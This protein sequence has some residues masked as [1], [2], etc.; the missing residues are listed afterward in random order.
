MG[1]WDTGLFS[2]DTTSDVRDT[3]I[4]FLKQQLSNED[5]YQKTYEEYKDLI[6]T[7]DE[8][9]F[10]YALADTQWNVGRLLPKVRD[11]ALEFI[12]KKGGDSLWGQNLIGV[13][14]WEST[15][16]KLEEKIKKPIPA[17]KNFVNSIGFEQNPWNIGDIYAYQFHTKKSIEHGL[18]G[19]YILL[20]KIGN[21]E[22]YKDTIFSVIQVFN[23][24]FDFVPSLDVLESIR[25]LPLVDSPAIN[26]SPKDI[27]S[28]LPTFEWYMKATML[29]EKKND[30]PK[31]YLTFV[32]NIKVPEMHCAGND[33]TDFFWDKNA[34]EDWLI[35]YYLSWQNIE[36]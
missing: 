33:F 36:Y 7:E 9:L 14:K 25:V 17:E 16:L 15:L 23:C 4:K 6:G 3:Y 11:T 2:N 31:R 20:Q 10:W 34:M 32:G 27:A 8:P 26:G 18:S 35:D 13:S 29:Y 22:Y 30:Y 24:L 12:Q 1:T 28:Y 21:V 5:A 19:K